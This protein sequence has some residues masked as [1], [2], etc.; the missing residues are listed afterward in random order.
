MRLAI[1]AFAPYLV[2]HALFQQAHTQ[3]YALPYVPL[4]AL[5]VGAGLDAVARAVAGRRADAAFLGLA[6]A[7]A[8]A[9]GA[10][11]L[12]GVAAYGAVDSPAYAAM[13]EACSHR[14]AAPGY[15]AVRPLHVQPVLRPRAGEPRRAAL[16]PAAGDGGAAGR[17]AGGRGS[18]GALPRRAAPHR[19][20]SR[21]SA[22]EG[23]PR[24][25]GL[26]APRPRCLLSGE[27]PSAVHLVEMGRP[28]LACGPRVGPVPRDGPPNGTAEPVRTA[29]LRSSGDASVVL[30]AGEPTDPAAAEW[31][32]ELTLAGRRL[33]GR[34]CGA[35]WLAAYAVPPSG[36]ADTCPSSSPP[37]GQEPPP[38]RRS[39]CAGWPTGAAGD[40][41]LVRGDGWHYPETTDDGRPFRWAS[42]VARAMVNVPARARGWSWKARC[43]SVTSPAGVHRVESG[44]VRRAVSA[45]GPFRIELEYRRPAAGSDPQVRSGFRARRRAAQRRPPAARLAN[46]PLRDQRPLTPG[47]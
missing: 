36:R 1:L 45:S 13:R 29:Y 14:R 33:D 3:R 31:E 18:A 2:A 11:A 4:L 7:A 32:G 19:S 23:L 41:L 6:A 38:A 37:R 20:R 15:A 27:R 8:A 9:S 10:V 43:R 24:A 46:R 34:S 5:L 25:V 40:P 26:A 17:V 12:P 30:I 16:A 28:E 42:R 39:R 35:P 44:G 22:G 47:P 21:G